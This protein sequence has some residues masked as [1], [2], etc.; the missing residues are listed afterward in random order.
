MNTDGHGLGRLSLEL[1]AARYREDLAWLRRVPA[2][3]RVTVYDKSE[4]SSAMAVAPRAR[5][6]ARPNVG[7]EAETYLHHIVERWDDL[8]DLTVFVQGKPFDHAPDLHKTLRA[9]AE[10]SLTVADFLWLGFVIDWDDPDGGRL[11]R[12]WSKNPDRHP[13]P[14]RDFHRALWREEP[15]ERFV[16]YPGANFAVS[17]R[18]I[19]ARPRS[20]YE[21]ARQLAVSVENGAHCLERCWDRVFGVDGIPPEHRRQELPLYFKP[22]RRLAVDSAVKPPPR[23]GHA[24]RR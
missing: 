6:V 2:A 11:F 18:C 21:R 13:L 20:F 12:N 7:R 15:P 16:F 19:R 9:I 14:V 5:V 10:G 8:A 23:A 4:D 22:I 3:F 17:S 24:L 1:V